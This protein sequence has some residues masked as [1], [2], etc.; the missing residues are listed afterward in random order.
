ML[1]K[2]V[3]FTCLKLSACASLEE[4]ALAV[5]DECLGST[6]ELHEECSLNALQLRGAATDPVDHAGT[7]VTLPAKVSR[8][9]DA[10]IDPDDL[11]VTLEAEYYARRSTA[12]LTCSH[13]GGGGRGT[14]SGTVYGPCPNE[15]GGYYTCSGDWSGNNFHMTR[16][17]SCNSCGPEQSRRY[18]Q[19]AYGIANGNCRGSF[20][21]GGGHNQKNCIGRCGSGEYSVSVSDTK[22]ASK[23]IAASSTCTYGSLPHR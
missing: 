8:D 10:A 15:A 2:V 4:A 5:D 3:I 22:R 20:S 6:G 12:S 23:H 1:S 7:A 18:I 21:M 16:A 19:W 17:S 9:D 11:N 14:C 13:W